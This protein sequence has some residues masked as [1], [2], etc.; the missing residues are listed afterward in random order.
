[1]KIKEKDFLKI[2]ISLNDSIDIKTIKPNSDL[3][4][5]NILDSL[6]MV[7][8]LMILE[9]KYEFKIEDYDLKFRT[10]KINDLIKFLNEE[11]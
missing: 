10:Y 4:N 5:D 1:M 6:Q 9:E 11:I 3:I 7:E 8:F 2:I